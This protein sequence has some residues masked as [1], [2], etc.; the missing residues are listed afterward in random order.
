MHEE[1]TAITPPVGLLIA[2]Q[3]VNAIL[4]NALEDAYRYNN[5]YLC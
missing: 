5:Y 2:S 4:A 3:Y 1:W